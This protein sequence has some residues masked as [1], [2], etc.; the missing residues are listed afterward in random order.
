MT[1]PPPRDHDQGAEPGR[2]EGLRDP[3]LAGFARGGEWDRRAPGPVLA[4]VLAE[5]C[6]PQWRCPGVLGRNTGFAD[7]AGRLMLFEAVHGSRNRQA[8]GISC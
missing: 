1:Q 4:S 5:A 3:R 6:G 8:S 2:G 7:A